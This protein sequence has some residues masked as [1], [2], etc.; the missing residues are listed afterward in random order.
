MQLLKLKLIKDGVGGMEATLLKTIELE[1]EKYEI[2]QHIVSTVPVHEQL[3]L[4]VRRLVPH[5]C[6]L[7]EQIDPKRVEPN[8]D[9]DEFFQH[10]EFSRYLVRSFSVG[11]QDHNGITLSGGKIATSLWGI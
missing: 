1:E 2:T 5:L 4:A 6:Y 7:T 3:T 8:F 11:G 9:T 10:F